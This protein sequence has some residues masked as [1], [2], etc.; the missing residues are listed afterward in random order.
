[1]IEKGKFE[2]EGP[3]DVKVDPRL[4]TLLGKSLYHKNLLVIVAR[5]L[6]QNARDACLLAGVEPSI[7]IEIVRDTN[8][9]CHVFCQDNGIGMTRQQ[10]KEEFFFLGKRTAKLENLMAVGGFH[11]AVASTIASKNWI[12]RTLDCY[13]DSTDWTIKQSTDS[14][15]GTQV[16]VDLED[17]VFNA[18]LQEAVLEIMLS[19]CK[20]LTLEVK[21]G[22]DRIIYQEN[23]GISSMGLSIIP[24]VNDNLRDLLQEVTN[25]RGLNVR[26]FIAEEVVLRSVEGCTKSVSYM[27][28]IHGLS[29]YLLNG[30]VQFVTRTSEGRKPALF[31]DFTTNAKPDDKDYPFTM[32]R[33][34]VTKDLQDPFNRYVRLQDSNYHSLMHE[35][36]K[37]EKPQEV[38]KEGYYLQGQRGLR[39]ANLVV[40]KSFNECQYTISEDDAIIKLTQVSQGLFPGT[41]VTEDGKVLEIASIEETEEID[42]NDPY[43]PMVKV[44]KIRKRVSMFLR[45]YSSK[46]ETIKYHVKILHAWEKIMALVADHGEVFGIGFTGN[47]WEKSYR[48]KMDTRIFYLVNP[49]EVM[50]CT[51][52]EGMVLY[53]WHRACHE[54]GHASFSSHDESLSEAE[55]AIA[56]ETS[57]NIGNM[58]RD[59]SRILR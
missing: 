43:G 3:V 24:N 49:D 40:G 25:L 46:P 26:C 38:L 30:Q 13:I 18:S 8:Y 39:K 21:D 42:P 19:D 16:W 57:G 48:T 54:A 53:M 28:T 10:L 56:R 47:S 50:L 45:Y 1:M 27:G 9:K 36:D 7:K 34:S 55:A 14:I 22:G 20:G 12:V 33:E 4:I 35:F 41:V 6:L 58:L 52:P 32:S 51:S 5:E 59:F 44:K 17:S 29:V 11:I 37:P 23:A 31:F 15:Q 2:E